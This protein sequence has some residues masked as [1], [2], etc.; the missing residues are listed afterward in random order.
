MKVKI[1]GAEKEVVFAE[2]YTR[3]MDR[4]FNEILFGNAKANTNSQNIDIELVNIQKAN[5]YI[6]KAMTNLSDEDIDNLDISTYNEILK[7]VE[8]IK[9]PC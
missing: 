2:A 9:S 1:N 4:E 7:K 3:K 8:E 6:V 5:D